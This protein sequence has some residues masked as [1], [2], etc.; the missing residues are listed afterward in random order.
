MNNYFVYSFPPIGIGI[1]W[2]AWHHYN[3]WWGLLYGGFWPVWV[4]FRFAEWLFK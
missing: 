1:F 2:S 4:G 3:F